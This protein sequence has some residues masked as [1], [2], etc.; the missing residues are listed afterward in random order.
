ML[1]ILG[2]IVYICVVLCTV[3]NIY[4][5]VRGRTNTATVGIGRRVDGRL[6]VWCTLAAL[7]GALLLIMALTN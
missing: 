1:Q 6:L 5:A 2:G 4:I 7:A 3:F